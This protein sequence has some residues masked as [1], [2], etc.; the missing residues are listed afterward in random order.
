MYAVTIF[1]NNTDRIKHTITIDSLQFWLPIY[2]HKFSTL[3]KVLYIMVELIIP[4][5]LYVPEQ[6]ELATG[7]HII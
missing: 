7:I 6:T 1:L 2:I 3:Y 4:I 5:D